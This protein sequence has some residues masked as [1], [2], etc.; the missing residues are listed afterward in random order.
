MDKVI[1]DLL[2]GGRSIALFSDN[3]ARSDGSVGDGWISVGGAILGNGLVITPTLGTE[4]LTNGNMETGDPPTGW[5]VVNSS[6][7]DGVADPRT[8]SAGAQALNVQRGTTHTSTNKSTGSGQVEWHRSEGWVKSV[9]AKELYM[10]AIGT[11]GEAQH[12]SSTNWTKSVA[13]RRV[14][15]AAPIT[16]YFRIEDANGLQARLDDVSI[17]KITRASLY[18]TVDLGAADVNLVAPPLSAYLI[19]TQAGIVLCM[20]DATAPTSFVQA[21]ISGDYQDGVGPCLVIE[22]C[23]AGVYN[24]FSST[25]LANSLTK[26]FSAKKSGNQL[27][28]FYSEDDFGTLVGTGPI[29]LNA[30]IVSNTKHGL[31]STDVTNKFSGTFRLERYTAWVAQLAPAA[32]TVIYGGSSITF[33]STGYRLYSSNWRTYTYPNTTWTTFTAAQSSRNTWNNLMRYSTEYSNRT[34][35]LVIIDNANNDAGNLDRR[36]LE[37][38]VRRIWTDT[39]LCKI[40]F[41][42]IFSVTDRFD[43][44]S[45]LSPTN[46]T[47]QAELVAL[48]AAYGIPVVAYYD[49]IAALVA[50]GD[51]LFR[52][53]ADTIH[54]NALGYV[55]MSALLEAYLT[56]S[57][58]AN[59]Q[60]PLVLPSRVYDNGDYENAAVIKNGTAYDSISG[61]WVPSGTTISSG[62]IGSIVTYSATCQSIGRPEIDGAVEVSIDGGAYAAITFGPN[63]YAI[64]G[65]RAAHTIAIKVASATVTISKFWAI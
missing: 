59:R 20:D 26:H 23:V 22:E 28:I 38:L 52:H 36:A 16:Q 7:L 8:G 61:T 19:G 48:G 64:P 57:F 10:F 60:S 21:Y 43:D 44:A 56:P 25:L 18:A 50:G 53:M 3:F 4:L 14:T 34:P 33:S 42:K 15:A 54:P 17:K 13:T 65:G 35:N 29:T 11:V 31:M 40:I 46:G 32:M 2:F 47:Q 63:G 49:F 1:R 27:W 39:P 55:E 24:R 6:I 62:V 41:V 30:A 5:N 12:E 45:I 9:D 37:A 58:L 51:K